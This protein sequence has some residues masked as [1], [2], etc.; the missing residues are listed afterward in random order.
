M[1]RCV[2]L[3]DHRRVIGVPSDRSVLASLQI[4]SRNAK[5]RIRTSAVT[6]NSVELQLTQNYCTPVGSCVV[7]LRVAGVPTRPWRSNAA[8]ALPRLL[9]ASHDEGVRG[10]A[11]VR[12]SHVSDE[13]V[14][15]SLYLVED[16]LVRW[17]TWFVFRASARARQ[18][19]KN[20]GG[21]S[22]HAH[23]GAR[24]GAGA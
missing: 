18:P 4:R 10:A 5:N 23:H 15:H 17:L 6:L 21:C 2:P 13:R 24:D 9:F 22:E 1:P 3:R 12:R 16:V 7:S 8:V 19:C 11:T 14:R 20:A